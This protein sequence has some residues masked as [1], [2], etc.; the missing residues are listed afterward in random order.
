MKYNFLHPKTSLF[1]LTL[2]HVLEFGKPLGVNLALC[3]QTCD[4]RFSSVTGQ[5]S[6]NLAVSTISNSTVGR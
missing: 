3:K 6:Y 2:Q 5:P 1:D 4:L